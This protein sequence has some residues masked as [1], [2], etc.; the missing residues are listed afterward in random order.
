LKHP[1]RFAVIRVFLFASKLHI[2]IEALS[3]NKGDFYQQRTNKTP[4]PPTI[5]EYKLLAVVLFLI[6]RQ[7]LN[8]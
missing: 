4:K 1:K 5:Q 7:K 6:Q 2:F 3:P 8:V